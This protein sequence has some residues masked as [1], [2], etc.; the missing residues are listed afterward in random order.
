MK[1]FSKKVIA[2]HLQFGRH[3]LPWQQNV[4]SYR[5]FV[6]EIMLQQTQVASVIPYFTRFMERFPNVKTLALATVDEVL[7]YWTGLGYYA[8][9]RNLHRTAC[10]IQDKYRGVFPS[11]IDTLCELPGIGRSTAGAIL[12]LSQKQRHPI[13][14]GNVKRVLTR[15]FNIEGWP[16][17]PI[18]EKK[19]WQLS[20][21][22]TP[23][24]DV[25][26]YTQAI[27]DLGATL[28]TRKKPKCT[29]CPVKAHCLALKNQTVAE[30]PHP[31]PKQV[32]PHKSITL[33]IL[34]QGHRILLEKRA[35]RGIWGGLW[36]FPELPS[37]MPSKEFMQEKLR[38]LS[39]KNKKIVEIIKQKKLKPIP[40]SF[41]HYN[42]TIHPLLWDIEG[43]NLTS[44]ENKRLKKGNNTQDIQWYNRD[45][46]GTL[47]LPGPIKKLIENLGLDLFNNSLNHSPLNIGNDES[48]VGEPH[49]RKHK[50]ALLPKAKKGIARTR[51]AAYAG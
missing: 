40:H 31:K 10:I 9:A 48:Q 24:H 27:M 23:I 8:R 16:G 34:R 20:E 35:S 32:K 29:D 19:L 18:V 17:L 12:S 21:S 30:L 3:D 33:I 11:D 6:S 39:V 38:K 13:L 45:E 41:T 7:H 47:G 14:D 36:S 28:C 5:V 25:N 51:K 49:A 42:L 2:W 50:N 46:I 43:L 26:L 22:L 37:G 44:G 15:Y 4:N 1:T